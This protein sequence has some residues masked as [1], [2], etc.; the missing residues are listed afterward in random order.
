MSNDLGREICGNLPTGESREW[1]VTNG[2]G[3][4]ASGTIA[5]LV[6]RRYHGLLIAALKLP[7]NRNRGL[8]DREDHLHVAT[9]ETQLKVGESLTLV[10]S[11][12]EHPELDGNTALDAHYQ[13]QQQLINR[14][15]AAHNLKTT[16]SWI[17]QLVWAADQFIVNRPLAD[18]PDD[19][20][21]MAGYPWFGDW[22]PDTMISLP[23]LTKKVSSPVLPSTAFK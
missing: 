13:Y 8:S 11:T 12:E 5:G 20:T 7:L 17:R 23:G 16:P 4:Y 1:L 3:G 6:T 19:K 2:I 22:G 18:A 10:V 14:W 15:D 21:I 9:F